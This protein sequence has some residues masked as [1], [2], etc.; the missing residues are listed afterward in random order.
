MQ[1]IK[2]NKT[3]YVPAQPEA[4]RVYPITA[5]QAQ[6]LEQWGSASTQE[7][8]GTPAF[9]PHDSTHEQTTPIER[10]LAL[11]VRLLPF[12][13]IWFVL[14]LA[15]VWLLAANQAVGYLLFAVLTALTYYL[16]DRSEREFSTN[17]LERHRIDAAT[18]LAREKLRTDAY[19]RREVVH[20]HLRLLERQNE[21][22]GL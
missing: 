1:T 13:V 21:Q 10:S 9:I 8:P 11:I 4:S 3:S 16:M 15:V 14:S 18:S 6:L 12:T 2:T 17:G 20:A 22:Q 19:L 7:L 5:V